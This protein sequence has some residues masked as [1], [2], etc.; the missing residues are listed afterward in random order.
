MQKMGSEYPS[1]TYSNNTSTQNIQTTEWGGKD[2]T[3]QND[4]RYN[5]NPEMQKGW[6]NSNFSKE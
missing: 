2:Y 1:M 4:N 3:Y 5:Y 6:S